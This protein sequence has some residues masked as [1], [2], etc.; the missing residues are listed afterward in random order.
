M[1]RLKLLNGIWLLVELKQPV[2][3][4]QQVSSGHVEKQS[5]R[6]LVEKVEK[7]MSNDFKEFWKDIDVDFDADMEEWFLLII[8]NQYRLDWSK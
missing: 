2:V 6:Q 5:Q 8:K 7:F 1:L 4:V 3:H